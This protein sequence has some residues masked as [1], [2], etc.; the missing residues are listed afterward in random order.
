MSFTVTEGTILEGDPDDYAE[1][2][3]EVVGSVLERLVNGSIVVSDIGNADVDSM[4]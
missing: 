2:C 1:I 4:F 3:L